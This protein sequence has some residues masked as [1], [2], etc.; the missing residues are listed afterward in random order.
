MFHRRIRAS[1]YNIVLALTLGL[2]ACVLAG[3][4]PQGAD[5]D[6]ELVRKENGL[7]Y[8]IVDG[9]PYTGKAY[10]TVCG[11]ECKCGFFDLFIHWQGELKDGKKHGT[12]VYP[13]S[14]D[15]NGFFCPG[16]DKGV[17][18]VKYRD[19]VELQQ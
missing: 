11:H 9:K 15:N 7:A 5:Y 3:C 2:L 17:I 10:Q 14:R 18:E 16:D 8:R 1:S 12:F 6:M 19:G 4:T 13:S